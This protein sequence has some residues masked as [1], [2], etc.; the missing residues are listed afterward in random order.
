MGHE[1]VAKP[2]DMR[3][4][5]A[6]RLLSDRQGLVLHAVVSSWVVGATPVASETISA[7]LPVRL[8]PQSVRNTL[9]E[10]ARKGLV[11]KP[12]RSAGRIPTADGM[13]VFIDQLLHPS[14]LGP[15]E[16][17]DL[18]DALA[19]DRDTGLAES[20]TRLLSE[21]THQLGFVRA[22]R[23]ECLVLQHVSFVRVS[24]ERVM[25][26]LVS[27]GGRAFQR[28]LDEPGQGDQ[29]E[30]DR[31]AAT[32]N[33][34]LGGQSLRDVRDHLWREAA[35]LRSH[36]DGLLARALAPESATGSQDLVL[37]TRLVL[38][39]Q[40]EFRD[41][42]RLRSLLRTVEEKE[43]LLDWVDRVASGDGVRVAFGAD[44]A[45]EAWMDCALVAAS[46]GSPDRPLGA[47]GVIGPRRMDFARVVPLVGYVSRLLTGMLPA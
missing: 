7:V 3:P 11:R 21:R 8:S 20:A 27:E 44:G 35:A 30:L 31:M 15:Y 33:E 22:P 47:L 18:A 2:L 19:S 13:R 10:L 9:A 25:A 46:Y 39:D 23:L 4:A 34:R 5:A 16:K 28:V 14:E 1:P 42:E 24:S 40:P 45:D 26:V 43:R 38:L 12:H 36:A 29:A 37:G 41:P 32:L 6:P 17:Q